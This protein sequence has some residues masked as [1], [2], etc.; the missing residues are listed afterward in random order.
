LRAGIAELRVETG[1]YDRLARCDRICLMCD[2]GDVEDV[3]HFL[4]ECKGCEVE[5]RLLWSGLR[6]RL[7]REG[8]FG[9]K[10]WCLLM[11]CG[12]VE[13]IK[14]LLGGVWDVSIFG[15][16]WFSGKFEGLNK[17]RSVLKVVAEAVSVGVS[18]MLSAL[19]V[20]RGGIEFGDR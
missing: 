9:V 17:R 15:R 12:A 7:A 16:G 3:D 18:K 13:R 6:D 20:K 2:K 10:C 11:R 5:R 4:L 8:E 1:R 14:I 19:R